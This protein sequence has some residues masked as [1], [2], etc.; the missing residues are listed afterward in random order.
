VRL[1]AGVVHLP[2]PYAAG[3]AA[4][5]LAIIL[6][7]WTMG[8]QR[9]RSE[10]R[11]RQQ[12]LES[13][14]PRESRVV[15]PDSGQGRIAQPAA[16]RP[17]EARAAPTAGPARFLTSSGPT[18]TDPR[19]DR[20]N[21]LQLGS[22]IRASEVRSAI[23]L[24]VSRGLGCFGVVDPRSLRRNDEPLYVLFASRGFPSGQ[25]DSPEARRYRDQVLAAGVAWKQAGGVKDFKDALWV[26]HRQ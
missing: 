24:M 4:L 1:V 19:L 13:A 9:G 6:G 23:D 25:T 11:A 7:A 16:P 22:Q 20:H 5:V 17:G 2:L 14:L 10:E 3:A 18:E 26:L 15:E 12:A 21:Y 8:F